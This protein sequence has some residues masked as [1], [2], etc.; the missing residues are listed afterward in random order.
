MLSR[1]KTLNTSSNASPAFETGIFHICTGPLCCSTSIKPSVCCGGFKSLHYQTPTAVYL[2][3]LGAALT[4]TFLPLKIK[5]EIW[6]G[7]K[8]QCH[9]PPKCKV[10]VTE[11]RWTLC[12]SASFPLGPFYGAT[13]VKTCCCT[14][15]QTCLIFSKVGF[16]RHDKTPILKVTACLSQNSNISH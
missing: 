12:C 3:A 14:L 9:S 8:P 16:Y 7:G 2:S 15:D 10:I 6:R 5:R 11:K 1:W 4:S 13:K